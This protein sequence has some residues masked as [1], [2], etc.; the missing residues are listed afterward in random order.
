MDDWI[1][2]RSTSR[3]S[4]HPTA[5][6]KPQRGRGNEHLFSTRKPCRNIGEAGTVTPCASR[7]VVETDPRRWPL[8]DWFDRTARESGSYKIRT[9]SPASIVDGEVAV[10]CFG[11]YFEAFLLHPESKATDPDGSPCHTWTQGVL[12][13]RN[14]KAVE[15][16]RIGKESNRLAEN[17][18]VG[19]AAERSVSYGYVRNCLVCGSRLGGTR[20]KYCSAACR[21]RAYRTRQRGA[22]KGEALMGLRDIGA[23]INERSV[24]VVNEEEARYR[25]AHLMMQVLAAEAASE[26]ELEQGPDRNIVTRHAA[27]EAILQIFAV[28]DQWMEAGILPEEKG[29]HVMLMLMGLREFVSPLPVP[30]NDDRRLSDDLRTLEELLQEAQQVRASSRLTN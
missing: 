27:I 7:V 20:S 10:Q 28:V 13:F 9:G 21:Q 12:G 19:D 5:P 1:R 2:A 3:Q 18:E 11:D 24:G 14:V 15:I 17:P 25:R 23:R 30:G 29:L 26:E 8:I 16:E 6:V 22:R 4:S